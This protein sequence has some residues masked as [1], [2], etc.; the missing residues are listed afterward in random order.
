MSILRAKYIKEKNSGT[1]NLKKHMVSKHNHKWE[2]SLPP[3]AS[4]PIIAAFK[5]AEFSNEEF[6]RRLVKFI[7]LTDQPFSV[8]EA[9][10]FLDLLKISI[11]SHAEI[12]KRRAIKNR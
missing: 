3:P 9:E 10:S 5:K 11:P 1:G 7:I 4:S 8:V 2:E 6:H 12:P